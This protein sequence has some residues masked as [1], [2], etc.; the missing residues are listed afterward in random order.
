MKGKGLLIGGLFMI[1]SI[2]AQAT[3][4]LASAEAMFMYNFLRHIEW[5]QHTSEVFTI[6]VFGNTEMQEQLNIYT[7]NRKVGTRDIRV[8]KINSASEAQACQMVFVPTSQMGK[9]DDLKTTIGTS[10]C[11]I[12]GESEGSNEKGANI[13]FVIQ[14]SKLKFRIDEEKSKAQNFLVSRALIDLAL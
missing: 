13:E 3:G 9:I 2:S 1:M 7:K 8:I 4:G 6:G 11:L 5:P 12:V 10:P 14:D